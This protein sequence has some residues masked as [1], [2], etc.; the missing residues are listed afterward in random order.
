MI[1]NF[2]KK[3]VVILKEEY[4]RLKNNPSCEEETDNN[5]LPPP[6][7]VDPELKD[8]QKS[9][10]KMKRVWDGDE[11]P[12][13]EKIRRFTE[14]LNN[15][16]SRYDSLTQEPSTFQRNPKMF[17][18]ANNAKGT[19]VNETVTKKYSIEDKIIDSL[20]KSSKNQGILLLNHLK[21]FPKVVKWDE[22][23]NI[24]FKGERFPTTNLQQMITSVSTNRKSNIPQL[25]MGVLMNTLSETNTPDKL[26][27]NI[28]LK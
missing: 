2:G 4:E 16:K 27:K 21:K 28:E 14:E 11:V 10:L 13:D 8:L 20:P 15:L 26:I 7:L 12:R 6:P 24:V 5:A 19:D 18:N 23:G 25:S 3:Y 17:S 22:N 1:M 9:S